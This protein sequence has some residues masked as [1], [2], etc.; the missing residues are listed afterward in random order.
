[1]RRSDPQQSNELPVGRSAL[2]SR[3]FVFEPLDAHLDYFLLAR[4][5]AQNFAICIQQPVP[6]SLY[7]S[8]VTWVF[9]YSGI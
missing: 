2:I 1:M 6:H 3:G 4:P 9:G 8:M 7:S 5:S